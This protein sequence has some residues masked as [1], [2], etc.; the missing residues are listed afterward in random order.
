MIN[1]NKDFSNTAYLAKAKT[2]CINPVFLLSEA[3]VR[4]LPPSKIP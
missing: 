1:K 3:A 2:V 4:V